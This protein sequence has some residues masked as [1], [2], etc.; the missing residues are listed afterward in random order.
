MSDSS[1]QTDGQTVPKAKLSAFVKFKLLIES[2]KQKTPEITFPPSSWSTLDNIAAPTEDVV[3]DAVE[4]TT[5]DNI[6]SAEVPEPKTFA[7]KLRRL[8]DTLPVPASLATAVGG[9]RKPKETADPPPEKL[10]DLA[11]ESPIPEVVDT[12]IMNLLSSE[13][14]MNGNRR[15]VKDGTGDSEVRESV[16]S[17]LDRLDADRGSATDVEQR[18][19][20]YS[21]LEPTSDSEVELASSVNTSDLAPAEHGDGAEPEK[22]KGQETGHVESPTQKPTSDKK[23]WVPS[24]TS[25]SVLTTW[26]GYRLYLPPPVMER[27]DSR[28]LKVVQRAA[29]VTTA[30]QWFLN[31]VPLKI[32]P[33]NLRMPAKM[34]RRLSPFVGYVGMFIAWSWS[35]IQSYDLGNGVVLSATWLLP[36]ALIPMPWDA[37]DIFGPHK[38]PPEEEANVGD[39][40]SE[41]VTSSGAS[42]FWS[43][44]P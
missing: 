36:V 27:L 38:R 18:V 32:L 9:S 6:K 10:Q 4:K 44:K 35:R 15:H 29:M 40:T 34:L 30:L 21:P 37:G 16:W 13:S 3:G 39:S 41:K 25:I 1:P 23:V 31:K 5:N 2:I 42:W 24:T 7:N 28:Q 33:A 12:E 22:H 43:T 11:A 26:W 19:M 17:I 20:L 8:I 14:V